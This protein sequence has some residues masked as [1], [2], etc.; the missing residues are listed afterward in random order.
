MCGIVGLYLKKKNLHEKLG[1]YL[2]DMLDNMSSRGP[3]SAGF[4]IYNGSKK[5]DQYKYSLRFNDKKI[6]EN[7]D[8]QIKKKF[9]VS[10]A[11]IISDHIILQ[12]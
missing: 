9:N 1:F 6:I 11:K 10:S 12:T 2:S 4:A 8:Y 7:F 3:D 5:L